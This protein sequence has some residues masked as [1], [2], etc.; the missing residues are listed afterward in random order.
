VRE[1]TPAPRRLTFIA[2]FAALYII[3]GSTYLGIRFAIESIPP[4]LMAGVRF[5]L[6][7]VI[8]SAIAFWQ[9]APKSSFA[10]WRAALI[11]GGACF[12]AATAAL[13]SLSNGSHPDWPPF[14]S[15]QSQST[16]RSWPG[17]AA[18]RLVRA[19]WFCSDSSLDSSE[20]VS[21]SARPSSHRQS[22]VR[23][24]PD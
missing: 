18:L 23:S 2:A 22:A 20:S 1:P 3:W 19:P 15:R 24:T 13:L 10:E 5:F 17:S 21:S 6:A 8:M 12:S 9:G 14:W 16:S 4:L 7:G 11:V